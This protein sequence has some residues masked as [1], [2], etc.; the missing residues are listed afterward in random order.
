MQTG[1]SNI[2]QTRLKFKHN[3]TTDLVG[4]EA[5]NNAV[6]RDDV[7]EGK[8]DVK[9]AKGGVVDHQGDVF[10]DEEAHNEA[11]RTTIGV[12]RDISGANNKSYPKVAATTGTPPRH[13]R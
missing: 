13:S 2:L 11:E 12:G 4:D 1:N 8:E 10:K 9:G 7:V 5:R 6:E 3:T